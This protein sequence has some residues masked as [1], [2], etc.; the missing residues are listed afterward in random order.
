MQIILGVWLLDIAQI[1]LNLN[2]FK[3]QKICFP[4]ALLHEKFSLLWIH[5]NCDCMVITGKQNHHTVPQWLLSKN[6]NTWATQVSWAAYL[7]FLLFISASMLKIA[8]VKLTCMP[9]GFS[10]ALR[11]KVLSIFLYPHHRFT[12]LRCGQYFCAVSFHPQFS[13]ST[14]LSNL[15]SMS[16]SWLF[17]SQKDFFRSRG[18]HKPVFCQDKTDHHFLIR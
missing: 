13:T 4:S 2:I 7:L 14:S 15:L 16:L 17:Q 5:G 12:N 18:E 10:V 3:S 1:V 9:C 6:A 8:L 11:F